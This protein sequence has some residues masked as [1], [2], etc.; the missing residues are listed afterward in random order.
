MNL[1]PISISN[2][3][4]RKKSIADVIVDGPSIVVSVVSPESKQSELLSI[5][6][7]NPFR[8]KGV[9]IVSNVFLFPSITISSAFFTLK[10]F[11]NKS[12]LSNDSIIS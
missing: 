7:S 11:G 9:K 10:S 12:I 3:T 1:K 5:P 4:I 8:I 6:R 2:P